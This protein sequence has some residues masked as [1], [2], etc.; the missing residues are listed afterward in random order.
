MQTHT[1]RR[2]VKKH[3]LWT[4]IKKHRNLYIIFLPTLLFYLIFL[5]IPMFGNIIAFQDYSVTRGVLNSKFVG[6]DNFIEFLTSYNFFK[7]LRNTLSIS[8]L[9]LVV[10]FPLPII[11]SLLLNETSNLRFK[12]TV[13]TITY[14]PYF[15]STVVMVSILMIFVQ[16][17]GI[18]NDIRKSFGAE[19]IAFMM[20]PGYFP[21][22][23][24]FSTIWQSLGWNSI[25]YI[26]AIAGVDQELYEAACIDGAGR[27]KQM[28]HITLPGISSTI[29]I[30]LI[31]QVGQLLT[32]GSEKIILMYNPA[33]YETADVIS[34]FVYR[35]GMLES[36]YSYSA[37]VGMFNS[38]CN[39][40][41]LVI[42][43]TISN[44]I[45]GEGLWV[46][47]KEK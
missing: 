29:I 26:S 39:F 35:K 21:W 44:K 7:L 17:D 32:V 10:G 40:T 8:L 43:N 28:L 45:S 38:I 22:I 1:E 37:A 34:T 20:E 11:L 3:S 41:L 31:M 46:G 16:T 14:M 12:K 47:G 27:W 33:I 18:F 24:V 36:D 2:L 30:L 6:L 9:S 19:P 42:A 25:I 5:Y 13:Q 23:Y 15:I 4:E